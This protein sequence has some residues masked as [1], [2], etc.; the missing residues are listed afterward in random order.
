MIVFRVAVRIVVTL[1]CRVNAADPAATL[2]TS[3][4]ALH[5]A[6]TLAATATITAP[7]SI[8]R[9]HPPTRLTLLLP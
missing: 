9:A 3:T 2:F 7:C 5:A 6:G 8:R 4:P 1:P